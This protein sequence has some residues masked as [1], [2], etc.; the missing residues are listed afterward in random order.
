[1]DPYLMAL[2]AAA[3]AGDEIPPVWFTLKSGDLVVGSLARSDRFI[4]DTAQALVKRYAKRGGVLKRAN[5]NADE[6]AAAHLAA[7][8]AARDETS[9][10]FMTLAN[11]RVRWGGRAAGADFPVLRVNVQTIALW[12]LAGGQEIKASSG[13]FFAG[14][15][16]PVGGSS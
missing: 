3:E 4:D 13:G 5:D 7:L 12:W 14:V 8:E 11:A 15:S 16:I 9:S 2:I 1:M 6:R 10:Q